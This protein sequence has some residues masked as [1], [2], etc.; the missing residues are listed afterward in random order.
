LVLYNL[1]A[2]AVR[3]GITGIGRL[4]S[5]VGLLVTVGRVVIA[6]AGIT[7]GVFISAPRITVIGNGTAIVC[8]TGV[9]VGNHGFVTGIGPGIV[10]GSAGAA[11]GKGQEKQ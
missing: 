6:R 2:A 5:G 11:G 1:V 10:S 8:S 3:A 7:V 9:A 4:V